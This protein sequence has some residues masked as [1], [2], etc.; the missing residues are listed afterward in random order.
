M[1]VV[2]FDTQAVETYEALAA[3][4]V[5]VGQYRRIKASISSQFLPVL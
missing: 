3:R 4:A 2:S 5:R 1:Y